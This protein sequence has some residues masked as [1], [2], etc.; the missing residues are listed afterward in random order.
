MKKKIF[1]T[2]ETI[3]AKDVGSLEDV[4]GN[5]FPKQEKKAKWEINVDVDLDKRKQAMW[6]LENGY[7]TRKVS[8]YLGILVHQIKRVE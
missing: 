7:G 2:K 5:D 1:R 4:L 8:Q 3:E 6:Y